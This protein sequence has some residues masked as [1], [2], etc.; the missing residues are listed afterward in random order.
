MYHDDPDRTRAMASRADLLAARPDLAP[1]WDEADAAFPVRV[2][3]SFAARMD[4]TDPSDPLALQVLPDARELEAQPGD[5]LDP[6]G[7]AACS[8]VP[9]VVRKYDSRV[10]VLLTKRCHLYC[11]YCFR[12]DHDPAEAQDPSSDEWERAWA[13]VASSGV[14]EVILSG[15]D[16]LA[17]NDRRLEDAL[18]RAH[19]AAPV[20]RLHSRAPITFPRRVTENL[21]A[22]LR[23]YGPTWLVVHCNHP[24]EL[25]PDVDAALERLV[26]GGVPVLNQSVLLRGVNDDVDTLV[27]LC[28]KLVRRRVMPYYL[29]QTDAAR[30]NAHLRVPLEESVAL[31]EALRQRV[32]GVAMPRHVIDPPDGGGKVEA[33]RWLREGRGNGSGA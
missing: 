15:G 16:P 23:A 25:S 32:S 28:T 13:Y 11:R 21:V 18:K 17:V 4:P 7:D 2:T 30:G 26:G 33:R 3:A 27:E 5:L 14:E 20:V 12:R 6:V 1:I 29:H 9:W 8:P 19:S 24:R 31:V 22:L 10:L